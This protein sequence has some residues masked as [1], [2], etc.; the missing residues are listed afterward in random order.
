MLFAVKNRLLP[1]LLL[2]VVFTI[3]A[4]AARS[5]LGL[6]WN[7]ELQT[8][9]AIDLLLGGLVMAASDGLLHGL[10]QVT[11]GEPYRRCYGALVEFFR[12]QRLPQ[13]VA[14]GLLAGGEELVFRGTLLEWLRTSAGL[15]PAAAIA[16]TALVF[17]LLHLMPRQRLWPFAIW[18]VWEGALLGAV[19]VWSGSLLVVVVLHTLHDIGGF[20]VFAVQRRLWHGGR[21]SAT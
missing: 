21:R 4:F 20:G 19:Y 13:I 11:L 18:A 3:G 6:E 17:G 16:L 5:A 7:W 12:P 9:L 8:G 2:L 10:L 1:T 15:A 14:G